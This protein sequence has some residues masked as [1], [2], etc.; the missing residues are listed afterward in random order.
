VVDSRGLLLGHSG[1]G[2]LVDGFEPTWD[3]PAEAALAASAM[4]GA[5][6][7]GAD[8]GPGLVPG[9]PAASVEHVLLGQ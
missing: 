1:W 4:V 9:V 5:S 8:R 2:G 6:N 3:E 7:L